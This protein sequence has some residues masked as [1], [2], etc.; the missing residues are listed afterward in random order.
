M[1]K[2]SV[3]ASV[4]RLQHYCQYSGLQYFSFPD[5]ILSGN[6]DYTRPLMA[7]SFSGLGLWW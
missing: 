4:L 2:S 7:I 6:E 5:T 3:D 1:P